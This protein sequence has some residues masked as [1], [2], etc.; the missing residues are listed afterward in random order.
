MTT[1]QHT[2][3]SEQRGPAEKLL[4]LV[5][6]ASAH[7]WH[8]RPGVDV[9]GTWKPAKGNAASHGTPAAPGLFVPAAE[10]LYGRLLDIYALNTTLMAHFA[11]YALSNTDWRDLKVACAALMLVQ[12]HS[13]QPIRDDDGSVAFHGDDHRRIGEAMLLHYE[14][15]STRMMTPK[16]VLRVAELLETPQIVELNR[17]AGFSDPAANKAP[18]GRWP[19]AATKWLSMREAN[20]AMLEGL[21]R[22]GYK[23]TIKNIARKVGYKPKSEQFFA[24]LGWKQSQAEG[25]HRTMGLENLELQKR[26][27]FDGLSEA[28]ICEAIVTQRLAYKDAVGRLPADVGLTPAIM[29]ALLPSLSERDLRQLTPTLE[30]LGLMAVPEIRTAWE[31]AIESA[32]DQRGLNIA[33]NVRN[34]EIRERLEA[35]ADRAAQTAVRQATAEQDVHVMFLIDTS[36]SMQGALEKSI[37]ALTRILAG[38]PPEKLH[39]ASFDTMGTVHRPKAPTR[40][41]VK[42]MLAGVNVGGGTMHMAGV[43]ALHI[44]GEQVPKGAKL[45]VI[46]VGDEA[47]ESG[48]RFAGVFAECGYTVSA[49]ALIVNVAHTQGSTVTDAARILGVPFSTVTIEQFDD[50]YQVPRVLQTLLEAPTLPGMPGRTTSAWVDRVMA[51]PLLEPPV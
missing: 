9:A 47:G 37:E 49:L 14:R 10:D 25:G 8:N 11:S 50:P 41:A 32:T 43:R 38:F 26:E 28:E 23:E 44:A 15:K 21:V 42:H 7:L 46:V 51:T 35:S 34:Q 22:A 16:A 24:I 45:V 33:K 17:L 48:D 36:G 39:I 4:D 13:G 40:A 19:K 1:Q 3:P 30:E 27:R 2:L 20:P 29:V 5:L 12:P 31:A 6:N 18:L